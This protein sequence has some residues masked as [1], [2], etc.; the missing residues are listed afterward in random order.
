M[1]AKRGTGVFSWSKD[2]DQHLTNI[3]KKYKNP[4][5]WEPIA[6]EHGRGKSAKDCHERWIRYLKPGVRKGQW[7]DQEDQIVI[8]AETYIHSDQTVHQYGQHILRREP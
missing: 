4:R 7:T 5:D 8:E 6:K 1:G 3:M 2:D